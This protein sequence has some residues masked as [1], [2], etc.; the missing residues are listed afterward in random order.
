MRCFELVKSHITTTTTL[1]DTLYPL[2]FAYR[3]NR[4][5][6]YASIPSLVT[7]FQ[8]LGV[9]TALC[10]WNLDFLSNRAK[11]VYVRTITSS[12]LTFSIR[13]LQGYV[14]CHVQCS[15]F[16]HN[17]MAT[18]RSNS[19]I[20]F[21]NGTVLISQISKA[22]YREEVRALTSWCQDD[23]LQLNVEKAILA[24]PEHMHTAI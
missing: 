20:K 8:D 5:T 4:S 10:S 9:S 19:I 17:C 14:L 22:A 2:Q 6:D 23:S 21:A 15:M 16:M 24:Q 7:K 11:R 12:K 18:Q 13:V 1:L 3:Q